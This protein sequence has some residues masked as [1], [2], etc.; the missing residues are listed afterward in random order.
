M[1]SFASFFLNNSISSP[2]FCLFS[3]FYTSFSFATFYNFLIAFS[4]LMFLWTPKL[5][6]CSQLFGNK[7]KQL[8]TLPHVFSSFSFLFIAVIFLLAYHFL[9]NGW[10]LK[11][12]QPITTTFCVPYTTMWKHLSSSLWMDA[13]NFILWLFRILNFLTLVLLI[14]PCSPYTSFTNCANLF[15]GCGKSSINCGNTYVNYTN[16][17]IL[18]QQ[19]WWLCE[20][21]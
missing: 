7:P 11:L 19:I 8:L 21:T 20:Y 3:F 5:Q 1:F 16:F 17:F 4:A 18:C 12:I 15:A 14:P 2:C 6:K 9:I 13:S 10:S